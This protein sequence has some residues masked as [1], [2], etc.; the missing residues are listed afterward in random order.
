MVREGVRVRGTGGG[1]D[2][3]KGEC[4]GG[5]RMRKVGSDSEVRMIEGI[6]VSIE[7]MRCNA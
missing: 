3:G 1:D 5:V 2:D 7:D 6:R 4:E